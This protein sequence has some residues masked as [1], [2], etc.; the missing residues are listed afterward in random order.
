MSCEVC[1]KPGVYDMKCIECAARHCRLQMYL[2]EGMKEEYIT[3]IA[4]KYK[5]D[6]GRLNALVNKAPGSKIAA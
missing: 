4:Q 6:L 2:S 5:H 3:Q 1:S